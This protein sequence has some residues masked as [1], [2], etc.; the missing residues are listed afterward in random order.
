MPLVQP[1]TIVGKHAAVNL[2]S[3]SQLHFHP[4]IRVR[5]GLACR[6]DDVSLP[7]LQNPLGL[8]ETVDSAGGNDRGSQACR[9]N[10]LPDL[11]CTRNVTSEGA[12]SAYVDRG[13]AFKPTLTCIRVGRLAD[14][15]LLGVLKLPATGNGQEIHPSFGEFDTEI[16]GIIN[17][18]AA[19]EDLIAQVTAT[20]HIVS[21]HPR[22]HSG[23]HL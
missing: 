17:A 15:R 22:T 10:R 21:A 18:V 8:V 2:L 5:Q 16:D 3:S 11:L 13:H 4:P 20:D 9:A 6:A 14:P 23:K 12:R 1:F 19:R 7:T